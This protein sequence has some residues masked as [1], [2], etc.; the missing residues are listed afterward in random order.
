MTQAA[1]ETVRAELLDMVDR[2]DTEDKKILL[3]FLR[4]LISGDSEAL[5]VMETAR[6]DNDIEKVKNFC[7]QYSARRQIST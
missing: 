4:A 1:A 2:M 6:A 7:E 5:E 3:A